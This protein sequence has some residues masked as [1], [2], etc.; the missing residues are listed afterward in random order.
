LDKKE[1]S[2]DNLKT[3]EIRGLFVLG[4]LAVL[5]SIRLQYDKMMVI[6]GQVSFDIIPFI[7]LT[8]GLWSLYAFF[9]VLGLSED[10]IGKAASEVFRGLSKAFLLL[11]FVILGAVSLLA[12]FWAF[13]TRSL[14]ALGLILIIGLYVAYDNRKKLKIEKIEIDKSGILIV[15]VLSVMFIIFFPDEYVLPFFLIGCVAIGIY[16]IVNEKIKR[17]QTKWASNK[18]ST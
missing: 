16:I 13:P 18:I 14:W 5:A 6:I 8:I 2:K 17:R 9:M 15:F 4:L 12:F 10:V 1:I 11:D 3:E 7:N